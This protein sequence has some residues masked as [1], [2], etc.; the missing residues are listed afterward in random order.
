MKL[1]YISRTAV[2]G[3]WG[4]WFG[5]R[6]PFLLLSNGGHG[7]SSRHILAWNTVCE[8]EQG[9][10]GGSCPLVCLEKAVCNLCVR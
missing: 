8:D 4:V 1:A 9:V 10:S 5:C 2:L 6:T 7:M 3:V